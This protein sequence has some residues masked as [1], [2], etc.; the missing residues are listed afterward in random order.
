MHSSGWRFC[1]KLIRDAQILLTS[2]CVCVCA[3]VCV[4]PFVSVQDK[5]AHYFRY[6][7]RSYSPK[8][9]RRTSR[10]E[11]KSDPYLCVFVLSGLKKIFLGDIERI[12]LTVCMFHLPSYWTDLMEFVICVC[13]YQNFP[14]EFDFGLYR[15]NKVPILR[16][17]HEELCRIYQ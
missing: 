11:S 3:R 6:G 9:S 7:P 14:D 13:V 4:Y 5:C 8:E 17:I 10:N 12:S 1:R 15:S 16:E 2:F